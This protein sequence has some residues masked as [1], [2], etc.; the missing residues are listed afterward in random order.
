MMRMRMMCELAICGSGEI[1]DGEPA[2]LCNVMPACRSHLVDI[3]AVV[4]VLSLIVLA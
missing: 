3:M 4:V 2:W 1:S